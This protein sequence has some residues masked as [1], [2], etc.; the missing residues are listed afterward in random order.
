MRDTSCTVTR[1]SCRDVAQLRRNRAGALCSSVRKK[2]EAFDHL[3]W[4]ML[5]SWLR[6]GI[7]AGT[8]RAFTP[9]SMPDAR[10]S[11]VQAAQSLGDFCAPMASKQTSCYEFGILGWA[12]AADW[13]LFSGGPASQ[14][15]SGAS[16]ATPT[17]GA[18]IISI[19]I[20]RRGLTGTAAD[21]ILYIRGE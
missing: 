1:G 17:R 14:A 2:W 15:A 7:R 21:S 3:A 12:R 5:A 6:S 16:L 4:S 8:R 9:C 19:I 11:L 13:A 10:R 18:I 20:S